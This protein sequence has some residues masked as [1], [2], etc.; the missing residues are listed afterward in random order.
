[1]SDKNL[2]ALADPLFPLASELIFTAPAQTRAYRPEEILERTGERR[3]R[4]AADIGEALEMARRAAEEDLIVITG[5]LY[6]VGEARAR[7]VGES[8]VSARR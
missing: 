2:Q 1:M 5:S 7:L 4:L 8:G 3:A 6:L